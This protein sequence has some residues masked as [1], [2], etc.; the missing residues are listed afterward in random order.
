[1]KQVIKYLKRHQNKIRL[2]YWLIVIFAFIFI[3]LPIF[4]FFYLFDEDRVKQLIIEQFD[5]NNYHV[6]VVGHVSPKFWHGLSLGFRDVEVDTKSYD[7]LVKIKDMNCQL[8]WLDLVFARYK[9]RRMALNDVEIHEANLIKKTNLGN[10]FNLSNARRNFFSRITTFDVYGIHTAGDQ[11]INKV[12][13]GSIKIRQAGAGANF[14][15]GFKL[16]NKNMYSLVSGKLAGVMPHKILFKDFQIR[17]YNGQSFQLKLNSNATY[18]MESSALILSQV[19]GNINSNDYK[20]DISANEFLFSFAKAS[21]KQLS[22]NMQYGNLLV[23]HDIKVAANQITFNNY[24]GLDIDKI[25]TNYTMSY[26]GNKLELNSNLSD[27]NYSESALSIAAGKCENKVNLVLPEFATGKFSGEL[28]GNCRYFPK[29]KLLDINFVGSLNSA[30]LKLKMQFYN[31]VKPYLVLAGYIDDLDLSRIKIN[32]EKILPLLYDD[33]RLPFDWLSLIN[34]DANLII[35]HFALDRIN[36]N[37]LSTKFTVLNNTLNVNKIR[38]DVYKG[39]LNGQVKV[40][41]IGENEYNVSAKQVINNVNLQDMFSDLF[42]VQAI[43]GQAD[44]VADIV[45]PKIHSYSDLYHNLNGNIS[46][47]ASNGMFHGVDFNLFVNP[48]DMNFTSKK[49]TAFER[50]R[51]SFNFVNGVSNNGLVNFSSKYVIATGNG[52]V[53]FDNAKINYA[54][55]IKSALPRNNEKINSVLIPVTVTGDLFSPK[56]NIKNIHLY[57]R[58]IVKPVAAKKNSIHKKKKH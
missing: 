29:Q 43:S 51:S 14:E 11:V 52:Q 6:E 31:Q 21:I 30:P 19:Q 36:L 47:G 32:K 38:A 49:S 45:V 56:I 42:D 10:M 28:S 25:T 15:L 33:S 41:K 12:S 7:P 57:T 18:Y 5:S 53:D 55:S 34:I 54:L 37:N 26:N 9:V 3:V 27:I 1:M 44:L 58:D 50:L 2:C 24:A 23:M 4:F 46:L 22:L 39:L 40:E 8:S 17:L 35:K 20:S 13:D 16:D 48:A